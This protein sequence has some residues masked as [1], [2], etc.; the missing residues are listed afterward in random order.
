MSSFG[1]EKKC[2]SVYFFYCVLNICE[3]IMLLAGI[4]VLSI[5]KI[6][7]FNPLYGICSNLV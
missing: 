6:Q 5:A 4:K 3:G 7:L 1:L 2:C